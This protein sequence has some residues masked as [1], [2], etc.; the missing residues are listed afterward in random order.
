MTH[1]ADLLAALAWE[2]EAEGVRVC[3]LCA[4]FTYSEFHDVTN[5]HAQLAALSRWL[6]MSAERVAE[7]GLAAAEAGRLVPIPGRI[8]RVIGHYLARR[9]SRRLRDIH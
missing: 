9:G 5:T 2:L 7:E 3:A 4:G 1:R 8:N 6:W